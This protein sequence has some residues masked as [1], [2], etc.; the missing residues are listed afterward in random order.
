MPAREPA[1]A[2][3]P[4]D[5]IVALSSAPG[6]AERAIVRLSGPAALRMAAARLDRP[7]HDTPAFTHV[8]GTLELDAIGGV[9]ADVLV[10]R[11]PR[12]YTCEDLVELHVP[13][14]A[15]VISACSRRSPLVGRARRALASS[16]VA[17][18]RMAGCVSIRPRRCSR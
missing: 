6:V 13:G 8:R 1:P 12:S 10:F 2:H 7:L 5:T 14:S 9:T 4:A 17:P 11:A 16:R 3:A 15:P 18:S